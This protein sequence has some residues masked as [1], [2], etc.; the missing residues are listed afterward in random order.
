MNDVKKGNWKYIYNDN[1]ICMNYFITYKNSGGG[2]YNEKGQ[3]NGQWIVLW[4]GF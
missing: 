1:D 2:E 4:E 3:R